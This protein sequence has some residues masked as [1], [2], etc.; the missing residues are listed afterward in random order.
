[1]AG[2]GGVEADD[3]ETVRTMSARI[4]M[5]SMEAAFLSFRNGGLDDGQRERFHRN[6]CGVLAAFGLASEERFT[7]LDARSLEL[8]G[9]RM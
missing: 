9:G 6:S 7:Y 3:A 4:I 2:M 1:M 8:S 5:R